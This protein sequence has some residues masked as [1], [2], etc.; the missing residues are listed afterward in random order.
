M[1]NSILIEIFRYIE[2]SYITSLEI[3]IS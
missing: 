1:G 3:I 2:L